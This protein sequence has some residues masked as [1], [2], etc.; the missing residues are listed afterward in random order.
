[1]TESALDVVIDC[2]FCRIVAGQ[3]PAT[4]MRRWPNAVAIK[5]LNPV[6]VGHTLVIPR[7]HVPD[8]ASNSL[9]T[10]VV[11]NHASSYAREIGGSWNLITSAGRPATQTVM[12]LHVHLVPRHV[13]DGLALPWDPS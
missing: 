1:V 9:I 11:V 6:T 12:H 5:P 13:D 10:A 8:F 2:V 4:F 7:R 3:E